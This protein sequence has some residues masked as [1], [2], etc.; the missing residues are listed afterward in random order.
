MIQIN[1]EFIMTYSKKIMGFAFLKTKN[2]YLAEDLSQEILFQLLASIKKNPN[3]ESMDSYV[4]TL[5]CY[6]WSKF[7]RTNKKHWNYQNLETMFDVSDGVQIDQRVEDKV[8][9]EKIKEEIGYLG[10]QHRKITIMY[11]FDNKRASEIAKELDLN[12]NTVRWYLGE[13][14]KQLK[15]G[16]KMKQ[17]HLNYEP[18][19]MY[20]GHD[21]FAFD[22]DMAGLNNNLLTQNIALVCYGEPLSLTDISRKLGVAAAYI[23][24]IIEKLVYM[25][26]LKVMGTK[27][28]TNFFIDNPRLRLVRAKYQLE[29]IKELAEPLK[30]AIDEKLSEIKEIGFLGHDIGDDKL[31]WMFIGFLADQLQA[32][33]RGLVAVPERPIHKDGSQHFV[34]ARLRDYDSEALVNEFGEKVMLFADY[35]QSNGNKT[36]GEDWIN[37]KQLETWLSMHLGISWREFEYNRLIELRRVKDLIVNQ[38]EPNE[39]DKLLISELVAEGYVKIVDQSPK[40]LIPY[41]NVEEFKIFMN[42]MNSLINQFGEDYFVSYHKGFADM[43]EKEIPSFLSADLRQY[44]MYA[45]FPLNG[46]IGWL[47]ESKALEIPATKEEAKSILTMVWEE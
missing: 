1:D 29:H 40:L 13:I 27:Y 46:V 4:Y 18:Q 6:T 22:S 19:R 34:N 43:Y 44:E 16:M 15:E 35:S 8:M 12:P 14:R 10:R 11:Y 25:D 37:S 36:R 9:I 39:L 30:A 45:A 47:I 21:G 38:T 5:C 33:A 41:F 24:G 3:I 42:I 26:Y 2:T 28:Q 23:E 20:C 17:E 32:K 31:K 7:L